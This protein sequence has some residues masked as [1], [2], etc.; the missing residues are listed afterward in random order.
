MLQWLIEMVKVLKYHIFVAL[1]NMEKAYYDK[2]NRK[3]L[4]ELMRSYGETI[5]ALI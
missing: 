2:V 4:F 5:V 1:G 3:K